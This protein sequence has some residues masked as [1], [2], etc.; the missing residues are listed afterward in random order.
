[1]THRILHI[2]PTLDAGGAEKQLTLLATRLPRDQFD[3]HVCGMARGGVLEEPLRQAGVPFA[4]SGKS[5]RYDPAAL[6]RLKRHI[7][8][9][10]PDLVHTWLFAGNSYGRTAALWAGVRRIVAGERC[11]DRWKLWHEW[12]IDRRLTRR[13]DR[14]ATNSRAVR[15]YCAAHGVPA[16]KFV[17]IP[18]GIGPAAASSVSRSELLAELGLAADVKLIGAVGR[19][20]PQKRTKELVMAISQLNCVR[21]DIHLLVIGDGPQRAALERY[22]RLMNVEE[23]VHFLGVRHDVSRF[24]PHFDCFWLASGYE[25]QSNALMEAMAA[26]IPVV[27]TDIPEN[28]ELVVSGE[29]GF[30]EP[31]DVRSA[32]G[33]RTLA[34][35]E[36][37]DLGRRIGDAARERMLHQFSI[38]QMVERYT[39]MYREVL[40]ST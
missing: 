23:R 29:S 25:G 36:D 19:L 20:W 40:G 1:M 21:D 33:R 31:L 27:A 38:E 2:I 17:V 24:L 12:A 9:L 35:L 28:R 18:N 30:L 37:T 14:I 3:V 16:E 5:W 4:V 15:D 6:W 22:R 10:R 7:A 34:I 8:R 26:G 39:A 11:V 13:T 32:F